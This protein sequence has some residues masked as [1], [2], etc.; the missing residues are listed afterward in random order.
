MKNQFLLF[1]LICSG[2]ASLQAQ[3]TIKVQALTWQD[4]HRSDTV[5]FPDNPSDTYRKIIMRYNMRCHD[6][7]VGN[8]STGCYEWDYSCNTFVT[9][10]SRTDSTRATA[11]DYTISGFSETSFPYSHAP[12]YI[13]TQY[14]QHNTTLTQGNNAGEVLYPP[15]GSL[16]P[17]DPSAKTYRYQVILPQS[18]LTTQGLISGT[19]MYGIRLSLNTP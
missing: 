14:I 2:V 7:L 15:T 17:F 18:I 4:T 5:D 1:I 9:D 6:A 11:P 16:I 12:T 10:P 8:G 13:Y 3:D 19:K